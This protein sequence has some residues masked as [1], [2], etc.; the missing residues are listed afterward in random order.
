MS[1]STRQI[2]SRTSKVTLLRRYT[3]N[4]VTPAGAKLYGWGHGLSAFVQENPS[5]DGLP[6]VS[7]P[8]SIDLCKLAFGTHGFSEEFLEPK[9]TNLASGTHHSLVSFESDVLG[10]RIAA[11]GLNTS[12]Q[13]GI[14]STKRTSGSGLVMNIPS[15]GVINSLACGREHSLVAVDF[16]DKSEVFSFGSS[17]YGQI[18]IGKSKHDYDDGTLV[19]L[20]TPKRVPKFLSKQDK[21]KQVV[22]GMDHSVILTEQGQLY[23]MGWGADGQLGLGEG[24]TSDHS[25]PS[26]IAKLDGESFKK[27][28][29][30]TDFT[31]ALNEQGKMYTWGNSEY[32]QC[33]LGSKIDRVLEPMPVPVDD[34]VVDVAAGG[35]FALYLTDAGKVYITGYGGLGLG[36]GKIETLKPALVEQLPNISKIFA[37]THYCSAISDSGELFIWGLNSSASR[38]GTGHSEHLFTPKRVEFPKNV[39]VE[40]LSLGV[41]HAFALCKE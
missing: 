33:M 35:S 8:K 1:I 28:S 9:I 34:K 5:E 23:S 13:L 27:I 2:L 26:K 14:G 11:V 7:T 20:R 24:S 37:T 6:P 38:L 4:A 25:T 19:C 18:G 22:C 40:N 21:V 32:G 36:E 3:T 29:A 17:M 10:N 41:D 39:F 12:G 30:S 31:I 16:G 15:E